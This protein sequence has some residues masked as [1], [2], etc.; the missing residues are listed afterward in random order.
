LSTLLFLGAICCGFAGIQLALRLGTRALIHRI[1]YLPALGLTMLVFVLV[2][3]GAGLRVLAARRALERWS[4]RTGWSSIVGRTT[5][6]WTAAQ[7]SPA[8]PVAVRSA[9]GTTAEGYPIVVGD[10]AW[11]HDALGGSVERSNGRGIFAIVRLPKPYP[12]T[13]VQRR[14]VVPRRHAGDDEFIRR[15]RIIL[16][17]LSLADQLTNPALHDAHLTGRVPPWTIAGDE[18]YAVIATRR[19]LR[20]ALVADLTEQMLFLVRLLGIPSNSTKSIN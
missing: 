17:D 5:W 16:D 1:G 20:P 2:V 12:F 8:D 11:A 6:P 18:L 19:P 9:L 10:L 15:F 7:V 3:V 14:R 13:S 4:A